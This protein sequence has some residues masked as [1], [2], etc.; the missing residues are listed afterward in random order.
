MKKAKALSIVAVLCFIYTVLQSRPS[1][2]YYYLSNYPLTL[3]NLRDIY[4]M[5]VNTTWLTITAIFL[6]LGVI[7]KHGE[8]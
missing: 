2:A 3:I 6:I 4:I 5:H 7:E 8:N 1:I